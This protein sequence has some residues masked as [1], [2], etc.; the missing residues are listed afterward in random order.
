MS[1]AV[2]ILVALVAPSDAIL[3][4]TGT[5]KEL[6]LNQWL[7][8][9][10]PDVVGRLLN[11]VGKRWEEAC[12]SSLRNQTDATVALN[13]MSK[14][15][16]KV[17]KAIVDGSDG[18]KDRVVEYMSDVCSANKDSEEEKVQCNK[19]SSQITSFMKDDA[20]VNRN[21]L[22]YPK[23]CQK[24]WSSDVTS[25]AKLV[26]QKLDEEDAAR[27]K[28]QAE[29]EKQEEEKKKQEQEERERQLQESA[30]QKRAEELQDAENKTQKAMKDGA[31]ADVAVKD[32]E[33]L[34]QSDEEQVSKL[35]DRARKELQVASE[36]EAADAEEKAEKVKEAS[37]AEEA[38]AKAAGDAKAE[39]IAEKA[40]EKV[41]QVAP[42]SQSDNMTAAAKDDEAAKSA[43][44]KM[45][46]EIAEKAEEKAEEKEMKVQEDALKAEPK[47]AAALAVRQTNVT[48]NTTAAKKAAVAKK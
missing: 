24:Y 23:F 20:E 6:N 17:A 3:R 13:E 10:H 9:M 31:K 4:G 19:F 43:G 12:V 47:K 41:E 28:E 11:Q 32:V 30:D 46:E 45:A 42:P 35:Q 15:C 25:A 33:A 34:M 8:G 39:A 7:T 2:L 21:D 22:D 36:K 40:V 16:A 1:R 14:S 18:D 26:A 37:A 38:A 48:K 5:Q 27:A 44:D 29:R